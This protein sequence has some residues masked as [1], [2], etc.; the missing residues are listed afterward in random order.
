MAS[1]KVVKSR[2]RS[3]KIGNDDR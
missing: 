2:L 1:E 3:E